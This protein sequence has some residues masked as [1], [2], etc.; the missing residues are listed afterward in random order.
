MQ[1][2]IY[3]LYETTGYIM[4]SCYFRQFQKQLMDLHQIYISNQICTFSKENVRGAF[5][6]SLCSCLP[7]A[8]ST[9]LEPA[10][11]Y[12]TFTKVG[13][14]QHIVHIMN[15]TDVSFFGSHLKCRLMGVNEREKKWEQFSSSCAK[16]FVI[17]LKG[18]L[19][20]FFFFVKI[21]SISIT[22]SMQFM[23]LAPSKSQRP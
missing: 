18:E 1:Y 2:Y 7:Q 21:H 20:I 3:Y 13:K 12:N 19:W 14:L 16:Q 11:T 17:V 22:V 5:P 8:L 4:D 9:F 15:R 10:P 23:G 6:S